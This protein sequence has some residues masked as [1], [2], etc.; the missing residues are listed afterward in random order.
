MIVVDDTP[1]LCLFT[2]GNGV[3]PSEELTYDYG[4]N[5]VNMYW[6][7]VSYLLACELHTHIRT[8][9]THDFDIEYECS[10]L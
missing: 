5:A 4:S 9:F 7:N 6:R 3:Q 1:H 8:E 2:I 10:S